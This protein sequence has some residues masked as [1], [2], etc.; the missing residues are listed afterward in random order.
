MRLEF[1]RQPAVWPAPRLVYHAARDALV[2]SEAQSI[3]G[4]TVEVN[5]SGGS[6]A[7]EIRGEMET[8]VQFMN[9]LFD[10]GIINFVVRVANAQEARLL[11]RS[12][13]KL[14][15]PPSRVQVLPE[16]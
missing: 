5:T 3:A 8:L 2:V 15:E 10:E 6:L 4:L 1:Y 16:D 11:A 12:F 14:R 9:L 13:P 7:F